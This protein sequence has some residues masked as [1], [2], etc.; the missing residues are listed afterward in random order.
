[1]GEGQAREEPGGQKLRREG[2]K[3]EQAGGRVRKEGQRGHGGVPEG[4][5]IRGVQGRENGVSP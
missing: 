2:T 5:G 4:G 3:E 1:M